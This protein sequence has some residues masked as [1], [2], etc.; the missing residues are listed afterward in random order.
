MVSKL[1]VSPFQS[2]NSPLD[3]PVTKRL[4]SGVH[5][6]LKMGHLILLVAAFTK[7]VVTALVALSSKLGG[8]NICG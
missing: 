5:V 1:K 6:M 7:R 8:G 3:A 2:V 4:P